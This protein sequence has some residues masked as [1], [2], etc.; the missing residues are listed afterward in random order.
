MYLI[1]NCAKYEVKE[2]IQNMKLISIIILNFYI[3]V[4]FCAENEGNIS[5]VVPKNEQQLYSS[6]SKKSPND[7]ADRAYDRRNQNRSIIGKAMGNV[8]GL[9]GEPLLYKAI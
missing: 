2:E 3:N 9:K 7:I 4:V 1:C 6:L 5:E 8:I